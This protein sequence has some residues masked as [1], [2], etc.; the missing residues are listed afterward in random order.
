MNFYSNDS[1][2]EEAARVV[3]K[4][5]YVNLSN[6]VNE[7]YKWDQT[8]S[9][10][11]S[12]EDV[13]KN[14]N[15]Q[16]RKNA[17]VMINMYRN[18]PSNNS[19]ISTVEEK[20]PN[21]FKSVKESLNTRNSLTMSRSG[22]FL[23]RT[24]T[25][26]K[27]TYL[28]IKINECFSMYMQNVNRSNSINN[29]D[30]ENSNVFS[31]DVEERNEIAGRNG[32]DSDNEQYDGDSQ[33]AYNEIEYSEE[34]KAFHE[35]NITVEL[36]DFNNEDGLV[37]EKEMDL[38]DK[39]DTPNNEEEVVVM[40]EVEAEAE[41][42]IVVNQ[43]VTNQDGQIFIFTDHNLQK[44]DSRNVIASESEHSV[45]DQNM[46]ALAKSSNEHYVLAHVN[47][48]IDLE[49][50]NY[51]SQ[52]N[53]FSINY[54]T[55]QQKI[56]L[57]GVFGN[58]NQFYLLGGFKKYEKNINEVAENEFNE[59]EENHNSIA[60]GY[61]ESSS[62]YVQGEN[63]YSETETEYSETET[64][65]ETETDY[66]MTLSNFEVSFGDQFI[67][68]TTDN[69]YNHFIKNDNGCEYRLENV[70]MSNYNLTRKINN[71]NV[72]DVQI[73]EQNSNTNLI[74]N[75]LNNGL[76]S[77]TKGNK[78]KK[79]ETDNSIEI[80]NENV[81]GSGDVKGNGDNDDNDDDD[82]HENVYEEDDDD[83]DDEIPSDENS[84]Q[85]QQPANENQQPKIQEQIKNILVTID[86]DEDIDDCEE[87]KAIDLTYI[88]DDDEMRQLLSAPVQP[89]ADSIQEHIVSD[90]PLHRPLDMSFL[91]DLG[92]R[93]QVYKTRER[94]LQIFPGYSEEL[95][96]WIYKQIIGR[97]PE[98]M[99]KSIGE[100]C[101]KVKDS[102]SVCIPLTWLNDNIINQY[103]SLIVNR[104]KG[105]IFAF[106]TF[107][108]PDYLEH[109][110]SDRT[111]RWTSKVDI[112]SKRSLLVPI[113]NSRHW[114][115]LYADMVKKKV[116]VYDSLNSSTITVVTKFLNY[117]GEEY[118]AKRNKKLNL[119]QFSKI[120]GNCPQ[121]DNLDDCGVYTCYVAEMLTRKKV[122]ELDCIPDEISLIRQRMMF[123]IFSG[124]LCY[125]E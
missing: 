20:K 107:T 65:T 80:D 90:K 124:K 110:Y 59:V 27:P 88:V 86:I 57:E 55:N 100:Y 44:V 49:P 7:M 54:D 18:C 111:C 34:E 14:V 73:I 63:E 91:I 17:N 39:M 114:S 28:P 19:Y 31:Y 36:M 42:K 2:N 87:V 62:E 9:S 70:E 68:T 37:D 123:E 29:E 99:I 105:K 61:N 22:K 109:G 82:D 16:L 122:L 5:A 79:N 83:V 72:M 12:E 66:N 52:S 8:S 21:N 78:Y 45:F 116:T 125:E 38:N 11:S 95:C 4:R 84:A 77:D 104:S 60:Q 118:K 102:L 40:K 43:I 120:V 26:T 117:L 98:N 69:D 119:E 35:N 85:N 6:T 23:K 64:E 103:M 53:I 33:K 93:Y 71:D 47:D 76:V 25:V 15:L 46:V 10:D 89:M 92:I 13:P 94:I 121:Q 106:D 67:N 101:V 51:Y 81:D 115:I 3:P 32:F 74:Q 30:V 108:F 112:F 113:F 97:E 58:D 48:N 1:E 24:S 56:S 96:Y 75:G 50:N 41:E